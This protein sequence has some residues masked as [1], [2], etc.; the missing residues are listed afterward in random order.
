MSDKKVYQIVDDFHPHL[1]IDGKSDRLIKSTMFN[2][3]EEF[4]DWCRQHGA[5]NKWKE[6]L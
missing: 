5:D 2:T 3:D 4:F 1:Y 6:V